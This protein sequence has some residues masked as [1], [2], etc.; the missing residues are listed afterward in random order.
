MK[1]KKIIVLGAGMVGKA[2]AID[3][4]KKHHV[5]AADIDQQSLSFLSKNYDIETK[6]INLMEE[7]SVQS[8]VK[9]FDLVVSAVPGFMGFDIVK[10]VIEAGKNIVD[11]SFMPE[12][13]MELNTLAARKGVTAITDCGVAP[14]MPNLIVGHH[15]ESM[16][17]EHF[18]YYVGGLPKVKVYPFYYKA[19]F[20]PIDVVEEYTRPA[21]FVEKGKRM[22]KPAMSEPEMAFFDKVGTLEAFYTDGLRSLLRNMDHIPN[23]KEK[24]LRYPGHIQLIQ[25]LK[26][27]GFFDKEP[28][29]VNN[30]SIRPIDFTS[31][32][33]IRDWQLE[34]EE[35]EF[36]VMRIELTGIQDGEAKNIVYELYDEYDEVEKITSMAR[37]TG[38][39]AT[40]NA[41]L[42][43]SGQFSGKGVFPLE[44]IGMDA[45][46]FEFVMKY[47]KERNIRFEITIS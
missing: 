38:F 10:T 9:G 2:I 11:I 37:T 13:F 33:L 30:A 23:M 29:T 31:K 8:L 25:A 14:G 24:T 45:D 27:A 21:R 46:C 28:L 19:P 36:T 15:N 40:A 41:E 17:I 44:L 5:C 43:L 26:I 35:R 4:A 34:P 12:D 18:S 39:T 6:G 16:E 32:V 42:V 3:L 22:V 7:E 47:L 1:N 20:S